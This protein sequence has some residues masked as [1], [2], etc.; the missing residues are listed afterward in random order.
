MV[1]RPQVVLVHRVQIEPRH[2]R[3]S[4]QGSRELDPLLLGQGVDQQTKVGAVCRP[5]G[6]A[7]AEGVT[8]QPAFF[9]YVAVIHGIAGRMAV[10]AAGDQGNVTPPFD[11]V[12]IGD[13]GVPRHWRCGKVDAEGGNSEERHQRHQ[14]GLLHDSYLFD[15]RFMA[16]ALDPVSVICGW[17]D[18]YN[19]TMDIEELPSLEAVDFGSHEDPNKPVLSLDWSAQGPHRVGGHSHP[20]AQI[21]YQATGVYR[22]KTELGSWVVPPGQAI[23]IPSFVYHEAFTNDSASALMLFVDRSCA[24]S[25]PRECMVVA[26]SPLLAELLVRAVQYGNDYPATGREA[27]LVEVMLDEFGNLE[28]APLRLPLATDKRLR[29]V[30]DLLVEEPAD[31]RD[32]DELAASCGASSRTLARLFRK[33][34]GLTFAE[35]RKQLRLLESIDLMGQGRSVTDVALQL[36]YQSTSAFIAMFRR[37]LGTSPGRYMTS[38]RG[39]RSETSATD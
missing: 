30:I 18:C 15:C 34:T 21:I 32:L 6:A 22:V 4:P 1:E 2:R 10:V 19:R 26:V 39:R 11:E 31:G 36:G 24:A 9:W 13:K 25:L 38:G 35:W 17:C 3:S 23:W 14:Y 7:P 29:R 5:P 8:R 27:R 33:E 37:S 12:R 16:R 20:R 28:P